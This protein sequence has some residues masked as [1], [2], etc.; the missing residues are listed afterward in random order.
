MTL[1]EIYLPAVIYA[2]EAKMLTHL[3]QSRRAADPDALHMSVHAQLRIAGV[4]MGE[5]ILNTPRLDPELRGDLVEALI[6]IEPSPFT[7]EIDESD[8][9][10]VLGEV[11]DVWPDS[12]EMPEIDVPDFE[13]KDVEI[14]EVEEPD[15]EIED[16]IIPEID[17]PELPEIVVPDFE[18]EAVNFDEIE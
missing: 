12:I 7:D 6:A 3:L 4:E 5:L 11:G 16:V 13:I 10:F 8:V 15:L 17:V 14:P 9:R 1:S 2:F 18:I